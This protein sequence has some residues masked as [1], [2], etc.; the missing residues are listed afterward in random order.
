MKPNWIFAG[1]LWGLVGVSLGAFGAHGLEGLESV[2]AE[3]LDWWGTAVQYHLWHAPVILVVGLS[4]PGRARDAAGWALLLGGL[5]FSGTLYSM[6]LGA[7]R[8][9]GAVTPLGGLALVAGWLLLALSARR[10][11]RQ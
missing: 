11:P 7:P 6:A 8:W 5:V 1:S 4:T 2:T 3:E 9:L 10:A